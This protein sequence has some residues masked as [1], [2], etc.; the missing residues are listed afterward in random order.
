TTVINSELPF[1]QNDGALWAGKGYN[2]R[3]LGGVAMD[4]GPLRIVAIPELVSSTN[5]SNTVDVTDLRFSR[6]LP[7]TRSPFSSP[8]NVVP[9]SID[10]PYRFGSASIQKIY[11]GQSSITASLGPIQVG[12]STENEW[13]GPA[14]RNPLILSDNAAGFPHAFLRT[15]RPLAGPVGV[16]EARWI[17]GA[18]EESEFFDDN[19]TNDVRS[20]SAFAV[21][22]KQKPSAGLSLGLMRSVYAPVDGYGGVAG[23]AF[24][25]LKNTGRP[26]ALP[27]TDSTMT[28]GPDQITSVFVHWAL[29]R[30]GLETYVEWGRTEFPSL[31]G[32]L[33]TPNHTRGYTSGVQ[34]VRA[35]GDNSRFRRQGEI[36]NVEQ[37]STYRFG[38]TGSFYTSRAVTQGYTNEGQMLAT[39][40]GPG[41]SG[42]WLAADWY[43]GG[44][45]VG[46]NFGR[47]RFNNDAFFLKANPHRCFHDVTVYP[48][49]RAGWT[50]RFFRLRADYSKVTRYNTFWQRVRGCGTDV[51]AI[52][53]RSSHNFSITLSTLGW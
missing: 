45:Q 47:T 39:G 18:L 12:G 17:V 4:F 46:A 10:L 32:L 8:F 36:T 50:N 42:E 2:V 34:W 33:L 15:G 35:T 1:G 30:Y 27:I 7:A 24:D 11:P 43:T 40:I 29:P 48:G 19:V 6:P 38:P 31:R 3:L 26:N 25:F 16:F 13:W 22:W 41:S 20:L 52:G 9:Y 37:S 28:P 49:V 5:Y 53:D 23:G 51:T 14:F 44:L 21:T